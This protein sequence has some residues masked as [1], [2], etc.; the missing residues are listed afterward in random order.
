MTIRFSSHIE[1][2]A[3]VL[4]ERVLA[5]IERFRQKKRGDKEAGGQLFALFDGAD[6]IISVASIPKWLD[7]RSRYGFHPNRWL[8]KREICAMHAKGLHFVGDWHTHPEPMPTPSQKDL[9]GMLD[10]V[11]QSEHDLRAFVMIIV[12][13]NPPPEGLYVALV[14]PEGSQQLYAEA[15]YPS[16]KSCCRN[17]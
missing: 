7:R 6:T 17:S 8:Q 13:I 11:R 16:I 12:G 4:T 2:P 3:V 9:T 10:C 5:T 14:Q 1:G 15:S